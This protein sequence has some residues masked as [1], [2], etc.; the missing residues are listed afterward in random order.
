MILMFG[1]FIIAFKLKHFRNSKFLGRSVRRALGDFGVPI[2]IIVMVLLDFLIHDTYTDKLVM[3]E[4]IRPSDPSVHGESN[5]LT[6]NHGSC[7]GDVKGS[8]RT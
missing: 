1:T 4:G 8:L 5:F 3:P 7:S 2:S 6:S